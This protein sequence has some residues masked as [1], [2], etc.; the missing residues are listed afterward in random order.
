VRAAVRDV[1]AFPQLAH[2][3]HCLLEHRQPLVGCRPF[4]AGD[5]LVQVLAS[6]D[7][8]EEAARHETC[9]RRRGMGDDRRVNPYER[10]GHSGSKPELLC[11]LRDP[12]DHGPD[13]RAVALAVRP[14]MDVVGDQAEPEAG[15]FGEASVPN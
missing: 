1:V 2:Q 15:F 6:A 13:E 10:T 14:R 4:R 8:E 12:P 9:G 7:T 11:R 3:L 5:V